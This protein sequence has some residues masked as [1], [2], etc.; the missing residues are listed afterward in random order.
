MPAKRRKIEAESLDDSQPVKR[1]ILPA[2]DIQKPVFPV[3]K[4]V[5]HPILPSKVEE[6]VN[7]SWLDSIE[8]AASSNPPEPQE[9][10]NAGSI[11]APFQPP[12]SSC[13]ASILKSLLDPSNFRGLKSYT[14]QFTKDMKNYRF[15]SNREIT[16]LQKKAK[17]KRKQL[18]KTSELE[19]K[20][21]ISSR[22]PSDPKKKP[23][24]LNKRRRI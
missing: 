20:S 9:H 12:V 10:E 5:H 11:D 7:L 23:I 6:S 17:L 2:K 24:Q 4:E 21:A 14:H 1:V 13:S 15:Y 19:W 3:K 16:E 8:V 18:Q 22:K